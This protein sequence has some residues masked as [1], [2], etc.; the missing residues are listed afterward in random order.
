[1]P[2]IFMVAAVVSFFFL[3]CLTYK[4]EPKQTAMTTKKTI[5]TIGIYNLG[6]FGGQREGAIEI[7]GQYKIITDT[8]EFIA[9]KIGGYGNFTSFPEVE[10]PEPAI[11]SKPAYRFIHDVLIDKIKKANQNESTEIEIKQFNE[12]KRHKIH[13]ARIS[14]NIDFGDKVIDLKTNEVFVVD[15]NHDMQFLNRNYNW[16]LV[17]REL[18]PAPATLKDFITKNESV[19]PFEGWTKLDAMPKKHK[20][21]IVD[22]YIINRETFI[23]VSDYSGSNRYIIQ[24]PKGEVFEM[25]SNISAPFHNTLDILTGHIKSVYDS[26]T[27]GRRYEYIYKDAVHEGER[28]YGFV[29]TH[30]KKME[31][32][33]SYDYNTRLTYL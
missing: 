7:D 15:S 31:D 33:S 32:I 8:K 6:F 30:Y 1:M 19:N 27:N 9:L 25:K 12:S 20:D 23:A 21:W 13:K 14:A 29:P 3:F 17:D 24:T 28:S 10:N 2:P 4:I 5:F 18:H 11:L 16:K 22:R 26:T